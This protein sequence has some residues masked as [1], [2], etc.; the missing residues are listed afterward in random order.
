MSKLL[1]FRHKVEI[2]EAS[3]KDLAVQACNFTCFLLGACRKVRFNLQ[4]VEMFTF[5]THKCWKKTA[6][7]QLCMKISTHL[8]SCKNDLEVNLRPSISKLSYQ[9]LHLS[10]T[11]H[12]VI[13]RQ[14]IT[15]TFKHS[16]TNVPPLRN[17]VKVGKIFSMFLVF[18]V[19]RFSQVHHEDEDD[20]D[21]NKNRWK[22]DLD[23]AGPEVLKYTSVY[24]WPNCC[25]S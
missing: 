16:L 13:S 4:N 14:K 7:I 3:R 18:K 20:L 19:H 22:P 12:S 5:Q 25:N 11:S 6:G 2:H 15:P 10:G 21:P 24:F 1:S 9:W 8:M 17:R 23:L